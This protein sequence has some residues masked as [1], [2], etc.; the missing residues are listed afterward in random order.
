MRPPQRGACSLI[1]KDIEVSTKNTTALASLVAAVPAGVLAYFLVSSFLTGLGQLTTTFMGLYG[2][3]LAACAGILFLPFAILIFGP[4]A[5]A[6]KAATAAEPEV[7]AQSKESL[8]EEPAAT[9]QSGVVD[10]LDESVP[11]IDGE[12][13]EEAAE[14]PVSTGEFEI[15]EP[16]PSEAELDAVHDFGEPGPADDA[17]DDDFKF[18]DEIEEEAPKKKK[19]K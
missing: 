11:D 6:R 9:D 2:V 10:A 4:K 13:I 8:A 1:A 14:A 19:K 5:P 16:T 12:A 15:V 3:T 17:F 7:D 18:D